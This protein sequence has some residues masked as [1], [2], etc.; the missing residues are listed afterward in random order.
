MT[1][2]ARCRFYY[3]RRMALKHELYRTQP[4]SEN[5]NET[6]HFNSVCSLGACFLHP[7]VSCQ[8]PSLA[9][10]LSCHRPSV[11]LSL[12]EC[13][14]CSSSYWWSCLFSGPCGWFWYDSIKS[15]TLYGL[16]RNA[17]KT[18]EPIQC[19]SIDYYRCGHAG[20]RIG[21]DNF[22]V[23]FVYLWI[24]LLFP[25][26]IGLARVYFRLKIRT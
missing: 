16:E 13:I 22:F 24:L 18:L 1:S 4:H 8:F 7:R 11:T 5:I 9:L 17:K 20:R 3:W 15:T 25:I 23:G 19:L 12:D 21:I 26:R 10:P 6:I 14:I 2:L